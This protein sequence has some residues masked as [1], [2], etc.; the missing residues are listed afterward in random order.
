MSCRCLKVKAWK[1]EGSD[2]NGK[3]DAVRHMPIKSTSVSYWYQMWSLSTQWWEKEKMVTRKATLQKNTYSRAKE[4]L[5]QISDF[6]KLLSSMLKP[7]K[8]TPLCWISKHLIKVFILSTLCIGLIQRQRKKVQKILVFRRNGNIRSISNKRTLTKMQSDVLL[9]LSLLS[10]SIYGL[11]LFSPAD[12]EL[13][14]SLPQAFLPLLRLAFS[15]L[16]ECTMETLL[17]LAQS[18]LA[19]HQTQKRPRTHRNDIISPWQHGRQ[20]T[21]RHARLWSSSPSTWHEKSPL[22]HMWHWLRPFHIVKHCKRIVGV[23][24]NRDTSCNG[25][26]FDTALSR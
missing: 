17:M 5:Q 23:E 2:L 3:Y 19:I 26:D 21:I 24:M 8:A 11:F 16:Y 14:P 12:A 18:F 25:K 10:V 1:K 15:T 6:K 9:P 13:P 4:C 7:G 20:W 22:I